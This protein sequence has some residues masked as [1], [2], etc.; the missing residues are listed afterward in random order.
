MTGTPLPLIE[1]TPEGEQ[2]LIPGVAPVSLRQRLEHRW[3]AP[4]KP[5]VPQKPLD[6]RLFDLDARRQLDL[7]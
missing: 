3:T 6:V 7:F 4:L 2:M 1:P 5:R